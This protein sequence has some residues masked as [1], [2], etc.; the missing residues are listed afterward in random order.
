MDEGYQEAHLAYLEFAETQRMKLLDSL[1]LQKANTPE[2][3]V[4]L[5]GVLDV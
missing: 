4:L 3:V 2:A 5:S 1:R